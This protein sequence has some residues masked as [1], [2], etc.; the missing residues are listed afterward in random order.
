MQLS[1]PPALLEKRQEI[2]NKMTEIFKKNGMEVGRLVLKEKQGETRLEEVFP[3]ILRK[4]KVIN[5]RI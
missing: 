4:E 5:V 3:E 1:V 2:Q